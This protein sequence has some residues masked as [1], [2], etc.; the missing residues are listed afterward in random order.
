M[1]GYARTVLV[2]LYCAAV[3]EGAW[4]RKYDDTCRRWYQG[5]GNTLENPPPL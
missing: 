3:Y 1:S 2:L 5:M 4:L